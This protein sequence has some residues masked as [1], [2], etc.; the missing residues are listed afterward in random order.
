MHAT[1][2]KL[3]VMKREGVKSVTCAVSDNQRLKRIVVVVAVA[4]AAMF[5]AISSFGARGK[6]Q[7]GFDKVVN[8]FGDITQKGG[9]VT[10][11]FE[12]VNAGT[13]P[14]VIFEAKADCGCTKPTYPDNPILPGEKGVISVTFNPRGYRGSFNKNVK[15]KSNATRKTVTLRITGTVDR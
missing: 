15:V 1:H 9:P 14:L 7:I 13:A 5:V 10:A 3:K 6:A 2:P 8:D 11:Q 4:F 12:F